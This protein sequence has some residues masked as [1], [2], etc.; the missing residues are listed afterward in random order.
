MPPNFGVTLRVPAQGLNAYRFLRC[1]CV[2]S[3][4]IIGSLTC[5]SASSDGQAYGSKG[6]WRLGKRR[7]LFPAQGLVEEGEQI[8]AFGRDCRG[9]S[10]FPA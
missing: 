8:G 2:Q 4:E 10:S 9:P 6:A 7:L 1:A 3:H 5:R